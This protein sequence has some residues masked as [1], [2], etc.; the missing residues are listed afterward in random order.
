MSQGVVGIIPAAG[1]GARLAPYPSPKELF[2]IGA[3]LV[4]VNGSK[5]RRPKVVSQYLIERMVE[6]NIN[7]VYMIVGE[8][9][10]D[11]LRYYGNGR[12]FGVDMC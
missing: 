5:E 9:K 3:Q 6:A 1:K 2:P 7:K 12:K 11:L 10:H 4:S 8:H